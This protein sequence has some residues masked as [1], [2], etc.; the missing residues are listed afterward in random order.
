MYCPNCGTFNNDGSKFC[1]NCGTRIEFVMQ[2]TVC[3]Q[4]PAPV[5]STVPAV[6]QNSKPVTQTSA[7]PFVFGLLSVCLSGFGFI[8]NWVDFFGEYDTFMWFGCVLLIAGIVFGALGLSIS[9][10]IYRKRGYICGQERAGRILSRIGLIINIV[11]LAAVFIIVIC[12]TEA[13]CTSI[14]FSHY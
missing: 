5:V 12:V 6:V 13:I 11:E 4:E 2:Q 1:N 3:R 10:S 14:Y 9:S 8:I 7:K